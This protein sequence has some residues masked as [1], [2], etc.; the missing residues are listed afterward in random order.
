MKSLLLVSCCLYLTSCSSNLPCV[1]PSAAETGKT[2][3]APS[4]VGFITEV[5][6]KAV[7]LVQET[8]DENEKIVFVEI[9]PSTE[10]STKF[11]GFVTVDRLALGSRAEIWLEECLPFRQEGPNR[12]V[13]IQVDRRR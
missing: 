12:A 3:S 5:R 11:G 1:L 10:M 8:K 9:S 13:A 4:L 7:F 2:P 6:E